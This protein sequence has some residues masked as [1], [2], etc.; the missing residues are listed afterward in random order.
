[1]KIWSL[2]E[3]SACREDLAA[4]HGL[5]L[6][7]EINGKKLLFDA[8]QSAAF[9]D[10]AEK[11]GVDLAQVDLVVLSH[12]H[13]DHSG[14]L[15]RFLEINDHAK[16]YVNQYVFDRCYHGDERYIGVDQSLQ[17]CGRLVFAGEE[18]Q[19]D[20]GLTLYACNTKE[21]CRAL[22]SAGL[23]VYED[24]AYRPDTFRHE[25]YLLVEEGEKRVLFSG[26]LSTK[27]PAVDF[28]LSVLDAPL[29]LAVCECAHFE[30][31]EYLPLFEGKKNLRRLCFNHYSERRLA[32]L[33]EMPRLLPELP[34]L[35]ATDG[36]EITL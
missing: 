35:R 11:L 13:Y 10:N 14:G 28:P 17:D 19:L 30:A 15:Q 25:Q 26:D 4:E 33:L 32:S 5:S 8:G 21:K 7:V 29:D 3:N 12:G 22:D 24:G 6:Y 9:A 34:M 23:T 20:D 36:L 1:M 16:I 31:T 2:M 27:G 18:L